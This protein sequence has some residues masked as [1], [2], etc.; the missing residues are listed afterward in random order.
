MLSFKKMLNNNKGSIVSNILVFTFV[1]MFVIL[2]IFSIVLEQ[3]ILL[4]KGQAIKDA[5]D[6][7]NIGA[8]N[9]M[10][11]EAKSETIV[12][13]GR[14]QSERDFIEEKIKDKFKDLLILNLNLNSDLTPKDNSVPDGKIEIIEV[15]VFPTGMAF[16]ITCSGGGIITRPSIH[17]IIKIPIKPSLYWNIYRYLK[18]EKGDGLK[19]YY[20]HV[21]TELPDNN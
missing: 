1:L 21:D 11:I 8:Y 18:N 2:P 5:I 6:V 14:N 10:D 4:L 15:S 12:V 20:I 17:S 19:D 9:C 3:Y 16:P 13:A 7:T